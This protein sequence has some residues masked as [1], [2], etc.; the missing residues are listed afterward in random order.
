MLKHLKVVALTPPPTRPA[1]P[2][3][4]HG[5]FRGMPEREYLPLFWTPEE[6]ALLRGTEI[7]AQVE[8]DRC[9]GCPSRGWLLCGAG[10]T[11]S[12]YLTHSK[13]SSELPRLSW[14]REAGL[15]AGTALP[16]SPPA[17]GS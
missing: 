9:G 6:L 1:P 7:A 13:H 17:T 11:P 16:Y 12:Q 5:Y 10:E 15:T 14:L 4:R 8:A 3:G 2:A